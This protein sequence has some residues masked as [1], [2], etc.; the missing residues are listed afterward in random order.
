ML[1]ASD[2]TPD[3]AL[4]A[5]ALRRRGLTLALLTAAYFCSYMDRNIIPILQESIRHD[6][7]LT[8]TELGL[9]GTGFAI[10][11]ATLG[12]P[13]ARL[14]DKGKRINIIAIALA[15]WSVM[16]ALGGVAQ[17]FVQ[18]LLARSGVGVGEAGSAAPSHS[19][20]ADLYPP[21]KRAGAMAIYTLGIVFGAAAGT[22]VGGALGHAYGWRVAMVSVGLPGLALAVVIKLFVVEPR[23]GL[24][25]PARST[26][27]AEPYQSL[28]VG[29]ASIWRDPAARHLIVGVTLISMIGY[30]HGQFGPSYLQR[31]LHLTKPQIYGIVAPVAALIATVSGLT[32]GYIANRLARTRGMHAQA[33]MVAIANGIGFFPYFILYLAGSVSVAVGGYWVALVLVST[34]LAPTFAMLQSRAPLRLRALWAAITLLCINLIG[35]GVGPP[36]IGLIS[37]ALRPAFGEESLRYAMI[38]MT[39]L[40]PWP[41]YHYWRAGVLL[42]R[43]RDAVA[44][45]AILRPA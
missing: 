18:L 13:V 1:M 22:I 34:Y 26:G 15:L 35:L 23:R 25:E 36:L 7:R 2:T 28:G 14:A 21:E 27:A 29:I 9:I 37:D 5:R 6:L 19:M 43:E 16:T 41:I 11:Y 10:F 17:N 4:D 3:A 12:I 38:A 33:W 20:I 8:D 45:A 40:G 42:K 44:G 30:A 32:G 31:S 39:C 24:S